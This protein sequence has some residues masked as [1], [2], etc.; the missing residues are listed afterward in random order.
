MFSKNEKPRIRLNLVGEGDSPS[1]RKVEH[2]AKW[3][4]PTPMKEVQHGAFWNK[5]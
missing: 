3:M 5:K 2:E 1:L 4:A